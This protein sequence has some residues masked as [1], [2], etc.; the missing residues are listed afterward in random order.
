LQNLKRDPRY[1]ACFE[2]PE[3]W[4]VVKVDLSQIELRACAWVTGD[5]NMRRAY[6]RG[7]DIHSV[8]AALISGKTQD[9]CDPVEWKK[10]RQDAKPVNFGLIYMMSAA[11]LRRTAAADYGIFLPEEQAAAYKTRYFAVPDGFWGVQ[12]WHWKLCHDRDPETRT[13]IGRRRFILEDTEYDQGRANTRRANTPIQGTAADILKDAFGKMYHR[14][15]E[16]PGFMPI[17]M[18]H[19]EV[20]ALMPEDRAEDCGQW[21]R[22]IMIEAGTPMIAPVPVDADWQVGRTWAG[23][24][25][26]KKQRADAEKRQ[27]ALMKLAA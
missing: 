26:E 3:G 2:A 12:R 9:G 10:L 22:Q 1:R 25:W 24:E 27:I 16:M 6:F 4:S 23:E 17:A 18:V 5:R 7:E 19:D 20:V 11:G 15:H 21:M 8:T 13:S 14:R